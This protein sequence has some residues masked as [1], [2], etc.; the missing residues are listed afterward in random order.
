[1]DSVSYDTSSTIVILN[2]HGGVKLDAGAYRLLVCGTTFISNPDRSVFLNNEESDSIINFTML[3][4]GIHPNLK[5]IRRHR[6]C[7]R[8]DHAAA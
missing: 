1:M 6:L 3:A 2:I 7:S 8:P 4:G 5:K